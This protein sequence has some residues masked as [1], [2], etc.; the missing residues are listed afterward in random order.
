MRTK[1]VM[2][3]FAAG[4]ALCAALLPAQVSEESVEAAPVVPAELSVVDVGVAWEFA[5]EGVRPQALVFMFVGFP[6]DEGR[7]VASRV[8]LGYFGHVDLAVDLPMGPLLL[9]LGDVHGA[10]LVQLPKPSPFP[11]V[12]AGLEVAIQ[13]VDATFAL[14]YPDPSGPAHVTGDY[15]PSKVAL[16]TLAP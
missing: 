16:L 13:C 2:A 12:L 14:R 10:V 6:A 15:R 1:V 7:A 3:R 8:D 5:M 4:L 9:G 11:G